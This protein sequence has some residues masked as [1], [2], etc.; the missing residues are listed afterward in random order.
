M[1][2]IKALFLE[3]PSKAEKSLTE[4]LGLSLLFLSLLEVLSH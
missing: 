3:K 1:Q 2:V 4:L